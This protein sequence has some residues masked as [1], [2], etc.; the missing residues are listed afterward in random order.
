MYI[1]KPPK[2]W[3]QIS[4]DALEEH[5]ITCNDYFRN[6]IGGWD[7]YCYVH[8]HECFAVVKVPG[9]TVYADP[10]LLEPMEEEP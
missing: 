4:T 8:N 7:Q 3:R 2:G 9:G 6:G 5:L 1:D 10:K